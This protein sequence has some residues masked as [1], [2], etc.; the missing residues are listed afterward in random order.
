MQKFLFKT[1]TSLNKDFKNVS[2]DKNGF[3][4]LRW[5]DDQSSDILYTYLDAKPSTENIY[6]SEI[7][8][9][10]KAYSIFIRTKKSNHKNCAKNN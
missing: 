2:Y 7:G 3:R 10:I 6:V 5:L 1:E 4:S 9:Y 8:D